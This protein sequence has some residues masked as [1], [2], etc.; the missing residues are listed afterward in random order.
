MRN[1]IRRKERGKNVPDK[2]ANAMHSENIQRVI[3]PQEVFQLGGVVARHA[4][5]DTEDNGRPGRHVAGSWRDSDQP[6]DDA[7]AKAHG[8]P[9]ALETVIN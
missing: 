5:T 3:A 4:A 7:R 2:S 1:I 6:S 8:G 9:F